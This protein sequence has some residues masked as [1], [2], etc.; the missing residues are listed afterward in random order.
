MTVRASCC[1]PCTRL[2]WLQYAHFQVHAFIL[3]FY[4]NGFTCF[5]VQKTHYASHCGRGCSASVHPLSENQSSLESA[6]EPD[7][8]RPQNVRD[9][10]TV[11]ALT[12]VTPDA[13]IDEA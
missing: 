11:C 9:C 12:M 5:H 4:L 6:A 2:K 1:A 3:G 8:S 10:I 13:S 7:K